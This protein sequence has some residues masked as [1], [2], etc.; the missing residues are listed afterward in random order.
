MC[1]I[2]R[3]LWLSLCLH[4]KELSFWKIHQDTK[5]LVWAS[6]AVFQSETSLQLDKERVFSI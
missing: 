5:S 6:F 4:N 2:C 3:I 1:Q